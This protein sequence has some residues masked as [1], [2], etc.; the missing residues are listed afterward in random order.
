MSIKQLIY[1]QS[2]LTPPKTIV[3][4]SVKCAAFQLHMQSEPC[5]QQVSHTAHEVFD[6]FFTKSVVVVN[7][8]YSDVSFS[9]FTKYMGRGV[10]LTVSSDQR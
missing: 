4:M 10:P 2:I 5:F 8:G 3:E 1:V 9:T 7:V 6:F